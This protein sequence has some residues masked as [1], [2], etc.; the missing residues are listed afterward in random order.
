MSYKT[1]KLGDVCQLLYGNGLVEAERNGGQFPV[2]GSNGIVGWHDEAITKGPTIIVGR[3]G[4]I[5][6]VHF[7]QIPCW[8][9]DTT[10]YVQ[11]KKKPCDLTWL[12]YILLVL[13][14]TKLNKSAA[15]PGL[16]RNDAY[17][18]EIPLPPLDEQ[19]RIAPILS[20]AD[21]LR[22]LHRYARELSDGYLQS[23]FL[24]MF[25]D[26]VSNPMGWALIHLNDLCEKVID[27][28]H[29]TPVYASSQT[30]YPCVRSSDIQS[31]YIVW[32][33]TRYLDEN[34]YLRR[35]ERGVPQA[36]DIFYCRE[37]GR[38]GNAA[39]LPTGRKA[40]LGQRMMLF[41]PN[42]TRATSEFIWAFLDTE[43]ITRVVWDLVGGSASPHVNIGDLKKLT[44]PLPPLPL[45]Q[46]FSQI[47]QKYERLR[48]QQRESARQAEHLFQ[49]LLHSAF[50]GEL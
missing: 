50:R 22:R 19:K 9:I 24:E 27:C 8:P 26:P 40:C 36:G 39:I 49:S 29:E 4:S 45:Q 7:S 25:G 47:A 38:L 5:G 41:R 10:Y 18:K 15:V 48:A 34:E 2:Y 20:K 14:L 13:D 6:E 37:G 21:R 12:Y 42:F 1:V 17:E 31:G 30:S 32:S 46:K 33:T 43:R 23:V 35:V 44:V 16:N 28:P 3:K 11:T